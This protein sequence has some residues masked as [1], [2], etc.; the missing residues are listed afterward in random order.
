MLSSL[1]LSQVNLL[2]FLLH[3]VNRDMQEKNKQIAT[4]YVEAFS[5]ERGYTGSPS[6]KAFKGYS[7]VRRKA[8]NIYVLYS[9]KIKKKFQAWVNNNIEFTTGERE[10]ESHARKWQIRQKIVDSK[11]IIWCWWLLFDKTGSISMFL[12]PILSGEYIYIYI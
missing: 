9:I 4:T 5:S 10:R 7:V 1:I 8:W 11:S 6:S 3:K 12:T 2:P